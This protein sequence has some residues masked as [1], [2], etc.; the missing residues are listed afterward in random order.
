[1]WKETQ[2]DPG[3]SASRSEVMVYGLVCSLEILNFSASQQ[4]WKTKN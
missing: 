1:M 4:N 3:T 2:K